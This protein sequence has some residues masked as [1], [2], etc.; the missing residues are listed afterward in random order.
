M[1]RSDG[2]AEFELG[3]GILYSLAYKQRPN[4][5][6]SI[7]CSWLILFIVLIGAPA[8]AQAQES[9]Q[10][11][12]GMVSLGGRSSVSLFNDGG[13]GDVG[14]GVGGEFRIRLSKRVNTEWFYDLFRSPIGASANRQDQHIGWSVLFYLKEPQETQRRLQPYILAGHCF[15]HTLQRS[16]ATPSPQAERWSSAVQAGAGTHWNLSPRMDLSLAGQY[17]IHLGNDIHTHAETD[18]SLHFEEH[19]HGLEG[20]LLFHLSFNYKIFTLW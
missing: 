13:S 3:I 8:M 6:S 19:G 20:H 5:R 14:T 4:L 9:A 11:R 1:L 7:M 2:G 18:G 17:M 10:D 16:N 12:P 15:D